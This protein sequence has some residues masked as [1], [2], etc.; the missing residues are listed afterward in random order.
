MPTGALSAPPPAPV[1]VQVTGVVAV[2]LI[3]PPAGLEADVLLNMGKM[4]TTSAMMNVAAMNR[5]SV[6]RV[7]HGRRV[8]FVNLVIV[9]II[10]STP[11]QWRCKGG[12]G[13]RTEDLLPRLELAPFTTGEKLQSS[14][15]FKL[16]S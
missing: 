15:T 1:P 14:H 12:G 7:L 9:G 6:T 2:G 13:D 8:R 4:P 16:I 3:V 10:S 11:A 5:R